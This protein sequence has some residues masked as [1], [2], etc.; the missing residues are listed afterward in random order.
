MLLV[1]VLSHFLC[2][3]HFLH[4]CYFEAGFLNLLQQSI[5]NCNTKQTFETLRHTGSDVTLA[6]FIGHSSGSDE[7]EGALDSR[8]V[9]C[10]LLL[11]LLR[12][13]LLGLL[14]LDDR[15]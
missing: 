15:P 9:V 5:A 8:F 3:R 2:N 7:G 12:S 4:H 14:L 1:E 6:F 13:L 11:F 10:S